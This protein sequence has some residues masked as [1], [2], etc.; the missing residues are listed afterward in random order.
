MGI[1]GL[2]GFLWAAGFVANCVLLIVLFAK[3]RVSSYPAFSALI[4]FG[5]LRTVWLFRIRNHYGDPLYDHTYWG[6]ALIDAGLQLALISE[7]TVKVFRPHGRWAVDVRRKLL[8]GLLSSSVVAAILASLQNPSGADLVE[9][10]AV[11]IG[12]FSVVLNAEL[13]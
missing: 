13:F 6:L 11:K 3:R 10:L 2:N 1:S 9:K 5:V 8:V 12:F 7:L 4:G